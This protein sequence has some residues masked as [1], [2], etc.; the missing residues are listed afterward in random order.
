[1]IIL[2]V[3]KRLSKI[4]PWLNGFKNNQLLVKFKFYGLTEIEE[5]ESGCFTIKQFLKRLS[6]V[7][8]HDIEVNCIK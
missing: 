8:L 3:K 1:M 5:E 7:K 2:E 6:E 4:P